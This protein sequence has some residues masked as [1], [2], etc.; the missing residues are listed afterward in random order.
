M[1]TLILFKHNIYRF[2]LAGTRTPIALVTA[3]HA[4]YCPTKT[5]W[6][7]N[8]VIIA[9][10]KFIIVF[11]HILINII[12]IIVFAITVNIFLLLLV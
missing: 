2:A 3:H 5:H 1:G 8:V 6:V 12:V 11:L 10:V 4:I 7:L 9:I